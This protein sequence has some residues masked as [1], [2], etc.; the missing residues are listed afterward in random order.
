[1]N[2]YASLMAIYIIRKVEKYAK[3]SFSSRCLKKLKINEYFCVLKYKQNI[4]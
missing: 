3:I 4:I 2:I 1:M